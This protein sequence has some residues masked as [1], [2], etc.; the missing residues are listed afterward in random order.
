MFDTIFHKS[1]SNSSRLRLQWGSVPMARLSPSPIVG[2]S[3]LRSKILVTVA[4]VLGSLAGF[5]AIGI[6]AGPPATIITWN[7]TPQS[8]GGRHELSGHPGCRRARCQR[9]RRTGSDG[10]VYR[11][12]RQRRGRD[13][14]RIVD[15]DRDQ[16]C[17]RRGECANADGKR[18]RRELQR[19]RHRVAAWPAPR[20][21]A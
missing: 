15:G 8:T 11:A 5:R 14:Q 12:G 1:T 7:G 18:V 4:V 21:S 17:E 6:A 9:Q 13:V 19:D 3:V 10:H 2:G 16:Q 20:S